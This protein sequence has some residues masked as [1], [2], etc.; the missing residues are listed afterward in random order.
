ME[1]SQSQESDFGSQATSLSSHTALIISEDRW[2]DS[3]SIKKDD[4]TSSNLSS[5][6]STFKNGDGSS[7]SSQDSGFALTRLEKIV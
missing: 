1:Q 6:L 3:S 5:S 2:R 4:D 7:P